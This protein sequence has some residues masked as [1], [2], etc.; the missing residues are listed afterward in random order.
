VQQQRKSTRLSYV[1]GLSSIV[2]NTLLFALKYYAGIVTGSVAVIADAWHTL[3]DSL[4]SLVVIVGARV[5][6]KPADREHP[7]GHGRA[8]LVAAVTIGILL[9]V[10]GFNFLVEAVAR[11]RNHQS[12]DFGLMA[13]VVFSV[14]VVTK[15]AIARFSFWA[16]K[17]TGS[18]AL[19]A[20]G[21]HH[22]SDAI[23][24]AIILAGLL[25]GRRLWWLD[26]V[27]G[28][29]VALLI[30][31]TTFDILKDAVNK[32]LGETPDAELE[33]RI[34]EIISTVTTQSHD[35]HHLHAHSY[36]D[37]VEL[38]LHIRFAGSMSMGKAHTICTRIER[39]I[40]EELHMEVT[41][42]PEPFR[43]PAG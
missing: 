11:L 29:V 31:Y 10:V 14:S 28:I 21:W 16:A 24:S 5:S 2:L 36:G 30:L 33:G 7:F 22:R 1:E 32:L 13:V 9:A 8:E 6:A 18:R 41:I 38:T 40:Q 39:A 4:T 43:E 20:D 26:G 35:I 37:H 27:L 25:F 42:H 34:R 23:A 3:S 17:R 12:A 19:R 15:E